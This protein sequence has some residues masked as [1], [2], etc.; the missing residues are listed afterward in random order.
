LII[1]KY[2]LGHI[3]TNCYLLCCE[4]KKKA[5]IIDPGDKSD[6]IISFLSKEGYE[7]SY[8]I[9][10]HGNF[11]HID[12]N[13][14]FYEKTKAPIAAH[15]LEYDLILSGGGASFFGIKNKKSPE[16]SVDLSETD[17]LSFGDITL[18]VLYTPGHTQGHISL[19]HKESASLFCGDVLF[20]RSIGRTDLPGGNYDQLIA[21]IKEKLFSLPNETI[22][23]P[24]HEEKTRIKDEKTDNPWVN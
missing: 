24:G 7:L 18:D 1:K 20:Y 3:Q 16:P 21:S 4:N 23:Y 19:Y 8:I 22:V 6:K 11:D 12:G 5:A 2:S 17:K 9:N 13:Y 14:F 15:K 10:T